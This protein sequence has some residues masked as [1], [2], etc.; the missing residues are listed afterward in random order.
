MRHD[1][2]EQLFAILGLDDPS[3][4]HMMCMNYEGS[5]LLCLAI[6]A[7]VIGSIILS[8]REYL[9]VQWIVSQCLIFLDYLD[10]GHTVQHPVMTEFGR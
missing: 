2:A 5:Q 7:R 8:A 10:L 6:Y 3:I 9:V 4:E 1:S